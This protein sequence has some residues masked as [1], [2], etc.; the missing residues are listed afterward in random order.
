MLYKINDDELTII[1]KF[2]MYAI[3]IIHTRIYYVIYRVT[4]EG[5]K[6]PIEP[7]PNNSDKKMINKTD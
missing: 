2:N 4:D 5:N 6:K 1:R 3:E 7:N